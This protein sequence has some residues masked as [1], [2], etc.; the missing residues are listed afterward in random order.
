[1]FRHF[2]QTWLANVAKAKMREAVVRAAQEQAKQAAQSPAAGEPAGTSL[3]AAEPQA[4]H[5]GV[6]FALGIESGCFEDCLNGCV[7]IRGERFVAREGG[8]KGRRVVVVLSGAGRKNAAEATEVLLEG[9]RPQQIISAGFA[10]GLHPAMKRND[11]LLADRVVL[12]D[13]NE[14]QVE[15]P[16]SFAALAGQGG[17]HVG[18]LLCVDQIVR[19][20]RQKEQLGERYGALAVDMETFAVAEACRQRAVPFVSIRVINDT[21]NEALAS[22]VEYLLVQKTNP[23]RWGAALGALLHRPGSAKDMYQMREHALVASLRLAKFLAGV[24]GS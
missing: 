15:V 6:V 16:A 5:V 7:T 19:T 13:D 14:L 10:G 11:I 18:S 9:H 8:L 17:V 23:A 2:L 3:A 4:C 1:M 20:P 12:P 24:V 22:E 21:V